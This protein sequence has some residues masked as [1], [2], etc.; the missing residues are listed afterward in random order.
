MLRPP[1]DEL[2]HRKNLAILVLLN[3]FSDSGVVLCKLN[4]FLVQV[5]ATR[6]LHLSFEHRTKYILIV[7][8]RGGLLGG[9][10]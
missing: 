10:H 7:R 2:T 1:H 6:A 9:F 3:D 5:S 8:R 4:L